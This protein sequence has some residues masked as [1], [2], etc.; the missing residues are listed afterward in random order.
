MEEVMILASVFWS[1]KESSSPGFQSSSLSD[2]VL[3][4]NSL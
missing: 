4:G 3:D 1:W 2:A